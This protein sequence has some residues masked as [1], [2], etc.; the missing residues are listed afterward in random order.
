MNTVLF[1]ILGLLAGANGVGFL[2]LV[3]HRRLVESLRQDHTHHLQAV[4]RRG[5]AQG[6]EH[7]AAMEFPEKQE[8]E[9]EGG[10]IKTENPA[11][12]VL[13]VD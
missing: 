1:F 13:V 6:Y 2:A 12:A 9:A 7:R 8:P 11:L 3:M 10:N 5:Y 4:R